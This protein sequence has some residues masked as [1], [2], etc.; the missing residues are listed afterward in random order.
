MNTSGMTGLLEM[1]DARMEADGLMRFGLSSS[2]PYQNAL[3]SVQGL[4]FLEVS[5][6]YR[7]ADGVS[8]G[9]GQSYGAFKDKS[10]AF[11]LRVIEEGGFG[12]GW[13]PQI[14]YGR[15]DLFGTKVYPSEFLVASKGV[16]DFDLTIGY[17]R[18]RIDGVFGGL[19][20]RPS[21]LKRWYGLVEYDATAYRS[22]FGA[23]DAGIANRKTGHVNA[24]IGYQS[25][26]WGIQVGSSYNKPSV[27][28]QLRAPT[29]RREWAPWVSEAPAYQPLN[30]RPTA[31]EWDANPD[32]AQTLRIRMDREGF[33]DVGLKYDQGVMRVA[34]SSSRHLLASRAVARAARLVLAHTPVEAE[35]IE[36]T[37]MINGMATKTYSFNRLDVLSDFFAGTATLATLQQHTQLRAADASA[38]PAPLDDATLEALVYAQ[39]EDIPV[40]TRVAAGAGTLALDDA[41]GNTLGLSPYTRI[42]LNDPSGA[43]KYELGLQLGARYEFTRSTTLEGNLRGRIAE[44]V[45]DVKQPSNSLLPKVRTNIAEYF[46]GANVKLDRLQLNQ[47]WQPSANWYARA[48]GGLYEEMFGG[49]GAQVMYVAPSGRWAADVMGDSLRQ[50][51]FKGTGFQAYKT[52]TGYASLHMRLPYDMLASVRAGRFLAKDEGARFELKRRFASGITMGVWY[53]H[54]NGRDITNPGTPDKP[55]QDKGIFI[56]MPLNLLLTRDSAAIA[57]F[58]LAPW[59]RDVGQMVSQSADLVGMFERSMLYNLRGKEALRGFTDAPADAE[60]RP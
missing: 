28:V 44:T 26:W 27:L 11:K 35:S 46:R 56:S 58:S 16:G 13:M 48:S 50:R 9:L 5:G 47:F 45:T 57:N 10:I 40:A 43:F 49:A 1:P 38:Q 2:K 34:F 25:D 41:R 54:T 18:Q 7:R 32:W 20:Y 19:R 53:T 29:N 17:G 31:A 12:Q 33:R 59:T 30:T 55:Y 8:G 22:D 14:S 4:P 23:T 36:L 52:T 42:F 60:A 24:A 21:A 15:E 6:R 37:P 39:R 3:I 51:D